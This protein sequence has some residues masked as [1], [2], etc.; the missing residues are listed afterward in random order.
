MSR[1]QQYYRDT[2]IKELMDKF[3]Y[4]NV[5][6]VPK[7]VKVSLNMGLGEAVGD[8]KIIEHPKSTIS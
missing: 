1:L 8:K 4:N 5:M 6:E 3:G 2:V 7:L